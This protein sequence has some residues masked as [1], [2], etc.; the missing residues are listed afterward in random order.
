MIELR[1]FG[2]SYDGSPPLFAGVDLVVGAGELALV[3]GPTGTGK[4]TLLQSMNGSCPTLY[5][6]AGHRRGLRRRSIDT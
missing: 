6:G 2:F 5:R 4:S 3:V 1:S